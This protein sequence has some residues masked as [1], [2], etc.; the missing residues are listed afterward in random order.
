[1]SPRSSSVAV[2]GAPT[3]PTV[4]SLILLATLVAGEFGIGVLAA[5]RVACTGLIRYEDSLLG[6][7][8][9]RRRV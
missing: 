7:A 3:L 5:S 4:S 8:R 6:P 9:Y 1:M 2:T